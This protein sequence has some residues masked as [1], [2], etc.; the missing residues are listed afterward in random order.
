MWQ[1]FSSAELSSLGAVI[2]SVL[3]A[4]LLCHVQLEAQLS[5]ASGEDRVPC[6]SGDGRV[7]L[8]AQLKHVLANT[9]TV[10]VKVLRAVD[11]SA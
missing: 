6:L 7:W 11:R 10:L 2:D 5:C 9:Q 8:V 4:R 3:G 1:G